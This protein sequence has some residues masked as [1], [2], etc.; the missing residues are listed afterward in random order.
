MGSLFL[1]VRGW[2]HAGIHKEAEVGIREVRNEYARGVSGAGM[3]VLVVH[4][5]EAW[6]GQGSWGYRTFVQVNGR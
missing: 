2:G 6:R 1:F 5:Y 4:E 3:C